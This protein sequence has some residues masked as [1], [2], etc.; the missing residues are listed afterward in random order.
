MSEP[1]AKGRGKCLLEWIRASCLD[2]FGSVIHVDDVRRVI[3]IEYP[4]VGTRAQFEEI[5]LI[6][7][8]AVDYVRNV[9]LGEGKYLSRKN[10]SYRILLPSENA[11]QVHLYMSHAD[12]KL[13]RALKLSR[14]SPQI[15]QAMDNTTARILMKREGIKSRSVFG[16]SQE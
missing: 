8:S 1:S 12:K 13:K 15:D 10:D 3:G 2:D 14:N 5:T 7:L 9:L 6:E 16:K 4:E 11:S